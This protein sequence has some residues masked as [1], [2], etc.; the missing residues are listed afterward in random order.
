MNARDRNLQ[1]AMMSFAL[2]GG[3]LVNTRN[4]HGAGDRVV[5]HPSNFVPI[6]I[7]RRR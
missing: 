6:K 5:S 1:H 3:M 7:D 2:L 4:G